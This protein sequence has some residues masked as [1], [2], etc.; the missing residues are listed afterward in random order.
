MKI[1]AEDPLGR[2]RNRRLPTAVRLTQGDL[3]VW[4]PILHVAE[5]GAPQTERVS[6]PKAGVQQNEQ[7]DLIS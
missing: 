6:D 4:L 2:S 3:E 5:I 1:A 7:Q